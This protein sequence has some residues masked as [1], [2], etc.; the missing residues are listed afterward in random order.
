MGRSTVTPEKKIEI[1]TLLKMGLIQRQV[2]PGVKIGQGRKKAST[3]LD[4][5]LSDEWN[6]VIWSDEAHFEVLNHRNR[7]RNEPSNFVPRVQCSGGNVSVR[8]CMPRGA[9]SLLMIYTEKMNGPAYIKTIQSALPM[10]IEN[11]FDTG[12]DNWIYM[13]VNT[14][15]HTSKDSMKWFKDNNSSVLK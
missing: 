1:K 14:P 11:T 10:F 12:N 4:D 13:Q 7:T 15:H 8:R 5:R 2:V 6:N 9:R 3:S